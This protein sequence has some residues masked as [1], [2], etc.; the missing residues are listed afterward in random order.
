MLG[1]LLGNLIKLKKSLEKFRRVQ[2]LYSESE[3]T[4]HHIIV[5][6]N[7]YFIY[8]KFSEW[9]HFNTIGTVTII[10]TT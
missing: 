3:V 10:K 9:N 4:R 8:R 1:K 7:N 2:D 6:Q 5:V